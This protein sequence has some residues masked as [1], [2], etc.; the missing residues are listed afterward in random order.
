MAIGKN[1]R[2]TKKKAGK[3]KPVDPFTRKEWYD[4]K[5]P[6]LF[7]KR[8]AGKTPINRTAGQKIAS[9]EMKGRVFEISLGD[10]NKDSDA[11]FRKMRLVVEDVQGKDALCNFYGMDMT[12]DKLASL[13]RK[14]QTTIEAS[15]DVR[16]TD[17]YVVRLFAIAFTARQRA[18]K[19]K[20]S[21]AQT[22]Q[23]RQIRKRMVDI[24]RRNTESGD[25]R[26]LFDK[27]IPE[28]IGAEITKACK[29]IYPL[30]D[31]Y[32]RKVKVVK[33]PKFDLDRLMDVHGAGKEDT[34]AAV[35]READID[36]GKVEA[37]AG[38]GG[39]L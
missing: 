31:V 7:A 11:D 10:L 38:S 25:L 34:G 39:R 8:V 14:C 27:L 21:Y 18:Q 9:E 15:V 32:M 17:G 29:E 3:K 1:K 13:F 35:K 30:K 20:T 22:A 24:M 33:R 26:K 16:T 6:S 4:V 19:S 28:A 36:K 5:V 37:L 12:R 2:V 23:V